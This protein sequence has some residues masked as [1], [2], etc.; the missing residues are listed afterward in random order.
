MG[1]TGEMKQLTEDIYADHHQVF[2]GYDMKID[3][4]DKY[5][6]RLTVKNK[7]NVLVA[8]SYENYFMINNKKVD[9]ESVIVYMDK[10][11][12]FYLP[13]NLRNFIELK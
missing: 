3:S 8:D 11:K 5:H 1:L 10:N 2:E 4:L 13:K 6:Y 7:R 9:L 12:T